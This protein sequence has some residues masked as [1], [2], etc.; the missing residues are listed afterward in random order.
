MVHSAMIHCPPEQLVGVMLTGMGN[1]GAEAMTKLRQMG[2][3]TIAENEESAVVFGMPAELIR[4]GGAQYVLPAPE[5][6]GQIDYCARQQQRKR[7]KSHGL[8]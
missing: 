2:G 7:E 8:G 5:I 1:D 6:A 3:R 4:L